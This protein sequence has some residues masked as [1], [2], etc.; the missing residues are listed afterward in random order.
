MRIFP[1]WVEKEVMSFKE[2][3]IGGRVSVTSPDEL[4]YTLTTKGYDYV[5]LC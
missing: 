3:K 1:I 5:S 2:I 4:E